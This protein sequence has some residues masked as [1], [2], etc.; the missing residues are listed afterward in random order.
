MFFSK[1][2]KLASE[3]KALEEKN[4]EEHRMKMFKEVEDFASKGDSVNYL[5]RTVTVVGYHNCTFY[6]SMCHT[7]WDAGLHVRWISNDGILQD[8]FIP[9]SDLYLCK[10]IS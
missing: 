7:H 5:G 9:K 4:R 10:K 1:K 2:K 3:E 8:A 6:R